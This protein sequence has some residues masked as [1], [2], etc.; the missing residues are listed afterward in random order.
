MSNIRQDSD[1]RY[2]AFLRG[3]NVGGHAA[4]KMADLKAAFEKMGFQDV[5]TV[6]ASGNVIFTARQADAKAL[7]AEIESG[8]KKAFNMN[9]CVLLRNRDDLE[10]LRSS[11]PFKGI[12]AAPSIRLYVTFLSEEARAPA[13]VIPYATPGKGLRILRASATEVLCVVDLAKG[14]GTPEAMAVLEREFGSSLTTRNW[15]TILKVL[16]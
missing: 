8:L 14:T 6:L 1:R 7:A 13:L 11:E 2:V 9:I 4:I 5:Q 12:E 10:R 3:I 15:N 16:K